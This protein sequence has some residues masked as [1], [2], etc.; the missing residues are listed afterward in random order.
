MLIMNNF[1]IALA[2]D[3]ESSGSNKLP[4]LKYLRH[5][6]RLEQAI[7]KPAAMASNSV[8]GIFSQLDAKTKILASNNKL[9]FYCGN[10]IKLFHKSRLG[11]DTAIWSSS[12]R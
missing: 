9:G 2:M 12:N 7:G 5:R 6:S 10:I 11:S 3:S 4:I 8:T 1:S